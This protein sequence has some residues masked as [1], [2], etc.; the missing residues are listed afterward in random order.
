MLGCGE[1][2]VSQRFRTGG[3]ARRHRYNPRPTSKAI[4]YKCA[5]EPDPPVRRFS[6]S[7]RGSAGLIVAVGVVALLLISFPAYRWFFLISVGIGVVVSGILYLWRKYVPIKE[8]EIENK[9]PLGLD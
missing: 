5:M 1:G 3:G 9:R 6:I 4:K 2:T 8:E 7:V